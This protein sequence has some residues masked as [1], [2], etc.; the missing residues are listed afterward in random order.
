MEL[1]FKILKIEHKEFRLKSKI[2]AAIGLARR[3]F[4]LIKGLILNQQF[5]T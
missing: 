1:D 5:D 2:V 4:A 3:I